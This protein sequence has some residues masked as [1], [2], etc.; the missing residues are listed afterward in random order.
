M[1]SGDPSAI[2]SSGINQVPTALSLTKTEK[3]RVSGIDYH[4][5]IKLIELPCMFLTGTCHYE[6]LFFALPAV[7]PSCK[8]NMLCQ[9]LA[10]I[11]RKQGLTLAALGRSQRN[12]IEIITSNAIKIITGFRSDCGKMWKLRK[13]LQFRV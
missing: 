11:C 4:S 3:P 6:R 13:L 12:C 10:K 9:G 2:F 7:Y 1:T 5:T 8:V